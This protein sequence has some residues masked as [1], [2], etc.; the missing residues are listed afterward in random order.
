[1]N[2]S[3]LVTG[4]TGTIGR[5]VCHVLA[6]KGVPLLLAG[7]DHAALEALTLETGGEVILMDLADLR[8]VRRA[9]AEIRAAHPRL[10]G[11]VHAAGVFRSCRVEIDGCEEMFLVNQLAPFLL[12]R[13][14]APSLQQGA[15]S[16]VVM[17]GAPA[18]AAPKWDDLQSVHRFSAQRAFE[19][20]RMANLL[21]TFALARREAAHGVSAYVVWPGRVRSPLLDGAPLRAMW[22]NWGA[23]GPEQAAAAVA[24][25]LLEAGWEERS[26]AFVHGDREI[27]TPAFA[28]DYVQQERLW[29]ACEGLLARS[30][31]P[32]PRAQLQLSPMA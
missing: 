14:L 32:P 5:A 6:E 30:G 27:D 4:A 24:R 12:L 20:T 28:R 21:F 9:A 2:R 22:S 3:V 15:P 13:E 23:A 16:R 8:S 18:S 26:A 25:V 29:S 31:G 19:R 1:M 10:Q 17:L 11:V 7:R